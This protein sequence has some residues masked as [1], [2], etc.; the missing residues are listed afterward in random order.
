[1]SFKYCSTQ[2]KYDKRELNSLQGWHWFVYVIE[3]LDGCYYTGMTYNTLVRFEQRKAKLGSRFTSKH[4]FKG[5]KY[6]EE[7]TNITE[8]R[9]REVFIKDLS[10]LRKEALWKGFSSN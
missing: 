2:I 5:V 6:I 1:M 7:F 9:E 4:G 10:K 8:A 3:C